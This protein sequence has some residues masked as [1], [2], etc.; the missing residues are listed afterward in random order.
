M[1][2]RALD[3]TPPAGHELWNT[4]LWRVPTELILAVSQ[5]SYVSLIQKRMAQPGRGPFADAFV[6]EQGKRFFAIVD[7]LGDGQNQLVLPLS[8]YAL[9]DREHAA[10]G[11]RPPLPPFIREV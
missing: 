8:A 1:G 4:P 2:E 6:F 9:L 5:S 10:F 7:F 11:K 3:L